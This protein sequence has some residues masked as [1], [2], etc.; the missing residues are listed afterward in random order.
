MVRMH[1]ITIRPKEKVRTNLPN[2]RGYERP[3]FN[4]I[5][6]LTV[7]KGEEASL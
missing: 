6:D 1:I 7:L 5:E 3:I 2:Q 4:G